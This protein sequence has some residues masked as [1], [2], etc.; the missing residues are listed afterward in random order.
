MRCLKKNKQKMYYS[1]YQ[2]STD[3]TTGETIIIDGKEVPVENGGT[4]KEYG[5]PVEFYGNISMSGSGVFETEYGIDVSGYS[6]ILVMNK[7]EI[8]I[9]EHSLIW[10]T[11]PPTD[12]ADYKV[13]KVVPSINVS[14]Y[15]LQRIEK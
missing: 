7:D 15:L 9:D 11:S 6:A 13:I 2:T 4:T 5:D 3:V 14:K 10:F 12:K 8:P 1:L